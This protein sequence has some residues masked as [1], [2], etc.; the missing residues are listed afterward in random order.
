MGMQKFGE[1]PQIFKHQMVHKTLIFKEK[2][3]PKNAIFGPNFSSWF[4][5]QVLLEVKQMP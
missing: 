5:V 1:C 4:P 2:I 3:V